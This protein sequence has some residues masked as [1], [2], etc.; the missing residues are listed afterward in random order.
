MIWAVIINIM[1]I[2]RKGIWFNHNF[3]ISYFCQLSKQ[4][5]LLPKSSIKINISPDGWIARTAE[6]FKVQQLIDGGPPFRIHEENGGKSES[7]V[8]GGDLVAE[9]KS[10]GDDLCHG[11]G[12]D[13]GCKDGLSQSWVRREERRGLCRL[14]FSP[15]LTTKITQLN[16]GSW[17]CKKRSRSK[18]IEHHQQFRNH[19]NNTMKRTRICI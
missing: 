7:S 14:S 15:S 8:R 5:E 18:H 17:Q 19:L 3:T 11:V 1:N 12:Y 2:F 16:K 13:L 4:N 6:E 10:A 9:V